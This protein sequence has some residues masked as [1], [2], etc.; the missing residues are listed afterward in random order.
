VNEKRLQTLEQRE[1]ERQEEKERIAAM[2]AQVESGKR[3]DGHITFDED[4][5]K[6]PKQIEHDN[7]SDEVVELQHQ[8]KDAMKWMFDS[9]ESDD[10]DT[11]G[12]VPSFP[13]NISRTSLN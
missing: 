8:S 10:D 1:M 9:D 3:K 11:P 12:N 5:E 13:C 7:D 4:D 2:L 6:A